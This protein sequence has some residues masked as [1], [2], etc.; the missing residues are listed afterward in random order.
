MRILGVSRY[1][2]KLNQPT[3]TTFRF[4]RRD[5]DWEVAEVVQI[6]YK[7][8]TKQRERLGTAVIVDKEVRWV[9]EVDFKDGIAHV[10][11]GE[12]IADGF[13]N[14]WQMFQWIRRSC[15]DRNYD[16]PMNKL[17]LRWSK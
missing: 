8:R 3:F 10:N 14:R 11:N 9:H 2:D 7:P 16:E 15:S 13:D 1:W 12:A 17:T 4:K 6:V 5:K